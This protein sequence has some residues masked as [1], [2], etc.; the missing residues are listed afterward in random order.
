MSYN[1]ANLSKTINF[2]N[3]LTYLNKFDVFFLFETHVVADKQHHFTSYFTNYSVH[4][5]A[6]SKLHNAGRA[7]GGCLF[8]YRKEL[9]KTYAFK[10]L[11]IHNNIVLSSKLDGNVFYFIPRYLNCTNWYSDLAKFQDFLQKLKHAN[12]CIV[13]DLNARIAEEQILD[14]NCLQDLP[15]IRDFRCSK[16]KEFN[17]QGKKLMELIE[18][19]G[20]IV[21]NGRIG[22]DAEG[23]YS[24]YGARGNSVIDYCVCSHSLL[25][26]VDDFCI[27]S[28][29]YSDHM[30]LCLKIKCLN[31]NTERY[32]NNS[33]CKLR[34]N[35]K[36]MPKYVEKLKD[37]SSNIDIQANV[38]IDD[39]LLS[40]TTKI[41]QAAMP[42]LNKRFFEPKQKWFDWQ[43]E[44]SRV[45]ML[46]RL[47]LYRKNHTTINKSRY[48]LSRSKYMKLCKEKKL[49]MYN[50][51]LNKLNTVRC[52]SDW[53]KLAKSLKSCN[54]IVRGNLKAD[55]FLSHFST[56][57]QG[58]DNNHSV[59]WCMPY[60]TD[61]ILDSPIE[62]CEITSVV[63]KLKCNKA[64]GQDGISYEFFKHAP[65]CFIREIL[66]FF[67]MIFLHENIPSSFRSSIMIPLFKKGD[68]SLPQNY[69]GLSL[70]N[71][72]CKIFN[73]VL[74]NRITDWLENNKILN[75][76]QAG[77]R[78]N[79][80]TVDNIFNL[81][82][83]V[84][85]NKLNG[86][87]TYVFFVDFSCAFDTIPRNSLFYKLSCLGLSS[88]IIRIL[89]NAYNN[90]ESRIWDGSTFSDSF[91]VDVGVKQGCIL[92]P[93]LFSIYLNDLVDELPGG[94]NVAG[95][96][97]KILLYADD[98]IILAETPS[99]LQNMI[100]A[101]YNYC[102]KWSLTVNLNKSKIMI[103]RRGPRISKHLNWHFG[104]ENIEIVNSYKYLGV[105]ITYNLSF[106][107]YL[108]NKLA[109]SKLA[110]NSTWLKYIN[111]PQISKSN[112]LKIFNSASRS[113][114]FYAAQVWGYEKFDEVEKLFRYFI[115][116][117]LYLPTTTPNYMLYLETGLPSLYLSTLKLHFC[118]LNKVLNMNQ[119][120]LPRILAE[121]II[122]QNIGWANEWSKLC[123]RLQY[124]PGHA[125]RP[126]CTDWKTILYLLES[127]E[128]EENVLQAM[129]SRN[130]D[131]YC[132]L[133]YTATPLLAN[134]FSSRVTS[135]II[136]ARG[137]LLDLNARSYRNNNA[138]ICT[139]CN[140]SET[141]D[142]YHFIGVCPI[143]K[144][145]RQTL[146]GKI[147]L[148]MEEVL[149]ILNGSD[150]YAL[151]KYIESSSKYR[152][153]IINEYDI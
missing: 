45:N 100:D 55:D 93:I 127:K 133:N 116:K 29:P 110:I 14:S 130:H 138:V 147:H 36:H 22:N 144:K 64:P 40:L 84:N 58:S 129:N 50:N 2:G 90:T 65:N 43:C 112:K 48:F 101:L 27:A 25:Q 75:E 38:S 95:T 30:P 60:F 106:K 21:L 3:F 139:I 142:T 68:P 146:F 78:K 143:F 118:Y 39:L 74:L 5:I 11:N 132:Q 35:I 103:F 141:E 37:L 123:Q 73:T 124:T 131:L 4:W 17:T 61:S 7:S 9:Q 153:L 109:S 83:I 88:K 1:V 15:H 13:G 41:K 12:F 76:Y 34:W 53:W 115:K 31:S 120:R 42:K 96:T 114:M 16:D 6:A 10:F 136:K 121:A 32:E 105:E 62:F 23:D 44:R 33:L 104:N 63:R 92:S 69:R 135:L 70:I 28:K 51:N 46:K 85:L 87:N 126:L 91:S 107:K 81:I 19:I 20:G 145:L 117:M 94:V 54:Q 66:S 151:Y 26:F 119:Q 125:N 18:D 99:E 79:Y 150:F 98:I 49:N 24:F 137:G 140:L 72:I 52:S 8:G 47:R 128:R 56:M 134:N 152:K 57:L 71:T 149:N 148:T 67:N 89:Q 102:L 82:N 111:H 59:H 113:I 108:T 86:K 80:S 122:A 97:I 77:F